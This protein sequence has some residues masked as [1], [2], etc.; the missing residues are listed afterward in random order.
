MGDKQVKRA[1]A[2]FQTDQ[3]KWNV[4]LIFLVSHE[5]YPEVFNHTSYSVLLFYPVPFSHI[6][7]LPWTLCCP[8]FRLPSS[9]LSFHPIYSLTQN[10]RTGLTGRTVE[11]T[12]QV[13]VWGRGGGTEN[14]SIFIALSHHAKNIQIFLRLE[15][16]PCQTLG[17][18]SWRTD[19]DHRTL[20]TLRFTNVLSALLSHLNFTQVHL[21]CLKGE[22]SVL[23]CYQGCC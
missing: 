9:P 2:M 11:G 18:Q 12:G 1:D 21:L 3:N 17:S 7:Q 10:P 6:P 20:G 16:L 23:I 15:V 13:W 22:L 5:N 4:S 19:C 8:A 14:T